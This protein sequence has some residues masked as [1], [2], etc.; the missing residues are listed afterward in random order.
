MKQNEV[1]IDGPFTATFLIEVVERYTGKV[2][3]DAQAVR[4]LFHMYSDRYCTDVE[5]THLAKC[6]YLEKVEERRK[7]NKEFDQALVHSWY[8]DAVL[9]EKTA[10]NQK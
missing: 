6:R 4:M 5:L 9:I 1:F 2:L 8:I 3:W 10:I 7:S